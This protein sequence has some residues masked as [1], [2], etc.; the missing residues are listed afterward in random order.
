VSLTFAFP[1]PFAFAFATT[2]VNTV[3]TSTSNTMDLKGENGKILS[4]TTFSGVVKESK[5]ENRLSS[6]Q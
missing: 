2:T 3:L 5:K 4:I 1:L 6:Y